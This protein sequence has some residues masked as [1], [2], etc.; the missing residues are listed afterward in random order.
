MQLTTATTIFKATNEKADET[1]IVYD[2]PMR[3]DAVP[4]ERRHKRQV[5]FNNDETNTGIGNTYQRDIGTRN[6][7]DFA[8]FFLRLDVTPA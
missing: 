1:A 3:P 2:A 4:A 6:R 7:K 8:S 5:E